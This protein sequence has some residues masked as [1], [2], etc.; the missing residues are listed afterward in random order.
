MGLRIHPVAIALDSQSRWTLE[1]PKDFRLWEVFHRAFGLRP[2]LPHTAS[3]CL[4]LLPHNCTFEC[5]LAFWWTIATCYIVCYLVLILQT[6]Q[7]LCVQNDSI[8]QVKTF[9]TLEINIDRAFYHESRNGGWGTV[10]RYSNGHVK[11]C[12]A[13]R[14]ENILD[15]L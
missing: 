5:V 8:H 4:P 6:G 9:W 3:L 7:N 13:W 1:M 14:L 10:I 2:N 11:A 15:P 12:G